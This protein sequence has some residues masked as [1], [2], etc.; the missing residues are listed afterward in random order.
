MK[1]ANGARMLAAAGLLGVA[2]LALPAGQTN[3]EP[4]TRTGTQNCWFYNK[5][6]GQWVEFSQDQFIVVTDKN[7]NQH[8][9]FCGAD[10]HW[11]DSPDPIQ[12]T[13]A[14]S[15]PIH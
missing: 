1:L 5:Q 12:T 10:G 4:Q 8:I 3:A 13:G 11:H 7:G 15:A 9:L 6:T 14:P 2:T